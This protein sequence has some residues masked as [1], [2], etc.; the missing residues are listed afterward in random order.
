MTTTSYAHADTVQT[1]TMHRADAPVGRTARLHLRNRFSFVLH[2]CQRT[3]E[4]E[5]AC[6][7]PDPET[8]LAVSPSYLEGVRTALF[9]LPIMACSTVE[10]AAAAV[11]DTAESTVGRLTGGRVW[12]SRIEAHQNRHNV[13]TLAARV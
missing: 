8:G 3:F 4:I 12:V 6:A 9:E 1:A 10:L 2:G 13:A 7:A 5:F 11:F